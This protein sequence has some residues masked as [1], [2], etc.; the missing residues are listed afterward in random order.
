VF[1]QEIPVEECRKALAAAGF[2]RLACAGENQ[3][4][5]VPVSFAVDGDSV[6][7]FSMPGQKIEWMRNNPRVCLEIDSVKSLSDWTS[8][9]VFGRYEELPDTPDFQ[10]ERRRAHELLRNRPMWWQPGS[11]VVT[12]HADSRDFTPVF[13][14]IN[15][16]SLTGHRGV[17]APGEAATDALAEDKKGGWLN[18]LFHPSK[19][20]S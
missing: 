13:Y 17:P 9:V 7:L 20:K 14:R 12:N 3:P 18:Q 11:V 8:I 10:R 19:S 15:I 16:D 1:V 6:Y 2:G 5:V 4:Y